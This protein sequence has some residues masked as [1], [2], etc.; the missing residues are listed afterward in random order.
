MKPWKFLLILCFSFWFLLMGIML[1]SKTQAEQK[2]ISKPVRISVV[3][4]GEYDAGVSNGSFEAIFEE[5]KIPIDF[6][7]K[8][9]KVY[10]GNREINKNRHPIN[11]MD[12]YLRERII[13]GKKIDLA[14]QWRSGVTI[15]GNKIVTFE[16]NKIFFPPERP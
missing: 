2:Y 16:A 6:A 1:G 12:T 7:W 9:L 8:T 14:G 13:K 10:S 3:T 5:K 15:K 4:L 11:Q